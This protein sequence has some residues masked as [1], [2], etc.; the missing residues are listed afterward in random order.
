MTDWL[1]DIYW[2]SEWPAESML[3]SLRSHLVSIAD[4]QLKGSLHIGAQPQRRL[5]GSES[6]A[7][8][9]AEQQFRGRAAAQAA[10]NESCADSPA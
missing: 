4:G 7:S 5:R 9:A 6:L 3:Y 8:W 2:G 1:L 10:C